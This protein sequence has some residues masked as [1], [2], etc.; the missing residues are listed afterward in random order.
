MV[1]GRTNES[2]SIKLAGAE[3]ESGINREVLLS[4]ALQGLCKNVM[5]LLDSRMSQ[6]LMNM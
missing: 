3:E 1:T 4:V 2:F 6:S 5:C